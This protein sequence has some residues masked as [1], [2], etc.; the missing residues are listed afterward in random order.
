M[1]WF[2]ALKGSMGPG[3]ESFAY[4]RGMDRFTTL[5][6]FLFKWRQ[7][8]GIRVRLVTLEKIWEI[9]RYHYEPRCR[10]L[11]TSSKGILWCCSFR[12][13]RWN[14]GWDWI[15]FRC[16]RTLFNE[17]RSIC[18]SL[19]SVERMRIRNKEREFRNCFNWIIVQ[20]K[21]ELIPGKNR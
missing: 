15:E 2:A 20:T 17:C 12:N 8:D 4:W 10:C 18:Y 5:S 11:N 21:N 14:C 7:C 3:K 6:S 19:V 9:L 16:Y 13:I 1:I